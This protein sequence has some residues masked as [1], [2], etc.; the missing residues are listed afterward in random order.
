MEGIK[1]KGVFL[2]KMKKVA[3]FIISGC[4]VDAKTLVTDWEA[5]KHTSDIHQA[6]NFIKS[7][8]AVVTPYPS[9]SLASI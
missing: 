4:C 5:S 9:S 8:R 1:K 3:G 6:L 7:V 2:P